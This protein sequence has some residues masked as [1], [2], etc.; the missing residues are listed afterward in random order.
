[1]GAGEADESTSNGCV[2]AEVR[3][4]EDTVSTSPVPGWLIVRSL[5]VTTPSRAVFGCVP[6]SVPLPMSPTE[7]WSVS[8]APAR[9]PLA[10]STHTVM[11]NGVLTFA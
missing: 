6:D 11:K 3:L 4:P 8:S 7:T 1:M 2:F 5:K 9:L 10:S